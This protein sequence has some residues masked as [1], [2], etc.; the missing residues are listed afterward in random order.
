MTNHGGCS[1]AAFCPA[2]STIFARCSATN[3]SRTASRKGSASTSL[4]TARTAGTFGNTRRHGGWQSEGDFRP[5][6]RRYT[7]DVVKTAAQQQAVQSEQHLHP[8][9]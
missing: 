1:R 6:F 2:S 5:F 9:H 3:A 4:R 8:H 7:I